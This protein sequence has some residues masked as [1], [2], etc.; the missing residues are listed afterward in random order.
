MVVRGG[1]YC[2]KRWCHHFLYFDLLVRALISIESIGLVDY[3]VVCVEGSLSG[4]NEVHCLGSGW[5]TF[6]GCTI[7]D[8]WFHGDDNEGSDW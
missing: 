5:P 6:V 8:L 3:E 1:W 4:G 2:Q 7:V